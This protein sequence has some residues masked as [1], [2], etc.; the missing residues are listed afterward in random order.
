L[1]SKEKCVICNEKIELHYKPMEKWE[2]K[3]T[4]CGKCY[5]KQVHEHYPGEHIRVN[6]DLD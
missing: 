6:L 5:S 4:L 3:G 1:G 2:I